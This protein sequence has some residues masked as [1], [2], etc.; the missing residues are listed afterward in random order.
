M[1]FRL[2]ETRSLAAILAGV[3]M[4][5]YFGFYCRGRELTRREKIAATLILLAALS[6]PFW[7]L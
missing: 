5:G 7:G 1:P 6:F 4:I 3:A 2:L